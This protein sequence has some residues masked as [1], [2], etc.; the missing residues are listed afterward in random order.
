M[1]LLENEDQP[2]SS[3]V[4]TSSIPDM[5]DVATQPDPLAEEEPSAIDLELGELYEKL[6]AKDSDGFLR[7]FAARNG[8][9][10][11][12][13]W[14]KYDENSPDYSNVAN[15]EAPATFLL[16]AEVLDRLIALNYFTPEGDDDTIAIALRGATLADGQLD[17][18]AVDEAKIVVTRPDHINFR[19]LIGFFFRNKRTFSL[20]TGS[21][22]PCRKAIFG[23]VNG[24]MSCNILPNGLYSYYV[25]RHKTLKPSLRLAVSNV[26]LG[27]LEAGQS[28]TVLRTEN[29]YI[30][31]TKDIWD[32]SRPLD[33][34]HCSYY[35]AY[36]P[37]LG[38]YFS[39][40]GCL[41]IRGKKTGTDQWG[42]F[43]KILSKIGQRSRVDL[44]LLTGKDAVLAAAQLEEGQPSDAL[45]RLR[46]GS[47]GPAVSRLQ[48]RLGLGATEYFGYATRYRLTEF[49]R[50]M[51]AQ[52]GEAWADGIYSPALDFATGWDVF[53]AV[54]PFISRQRSEGATNG[55]GSAEDALRANPPGDYAADEQVQGAA[56]GGPK[57]KSRATKQFVIEPSDEPQKSGVSFYAIEQT[58][59]EKFFVAKSTKYVK[60]RG[61]A[62]SSTL[63]TYD[64]AKAANQ[65]GAWAHFIWPTALG[66]SNARHITINS[67]D[68]AH[69]TWSFFQLAAHTPKD[70]LILLMREL[71]GLPSAAAYFADLK[72][73]DGRV[74]QSTANGDIDLEHE[75]AVP[76]GNNTEIQIPRFMRYLNPDSY[77][78]DNAEVL[79]AAKFVHWSFND[80]KV[81]QKTIDIALRIVKRKTNIFAKKYDLF[82]R[83][84]ELAIWVFDMFHQ[85]RGSVKQVKAALNLSS[86]SA[87]LDAL[88]EIDVTGV[89]EERL[90][91]VRGAVKVLMDEDVFAGIKFGD[92][93]LDPTV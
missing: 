77:R 47:Q 84:P 30:L 25:W 33:N 81:V 74:H 43:Q 85:G 49:Q 72:L 54:P 1:F 3:K 15:L 61:L 65:I 29:D 50:E 32:P 59:G 40:W 8:A 55:E 48:Q 5:A 80:P 45:V 6:Q 88:S 10:D 57:P 60:R 93:E 28:A 79:T 13:K 4:T 44:M 69:F 20:Y 64:H 87:Q 86:F 51:T 24:G 46:V 23:Y 27:D 41:T 67:Y 21:T 53:S 17:A 26:S 66:E 91:T 18:E 78:V 31:G 71:L 82:G 19:C 16:N 11:A 42:K 12:V 14:P 83:R 36:N 76:V 68:R 75:E 37:D 35:L 58:T 2:T 90:K 73:V 92:D 63:L 70:N 39:S 89:H 38:S 56:Q 9:Y 7:N 52:Q 34:V 62:R 22:V